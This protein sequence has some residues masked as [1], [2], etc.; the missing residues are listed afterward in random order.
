MTW[1]VEFTDEFGAWWDDL[2]EDDQ[3]KITAAVEVLE[4]HGPNLKRP[5][6]GKIESSRHAQMKELI[7]PAS[8]IRILF[9]FDPRVAGDPAGGRRQG[10]RLA[11]LVRRE[12]SAGGRPLR[13][14]PTRAA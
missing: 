5:V 9:A 1:E 14:L 4:T 3:E 13:H 8:D 11:R 7:P 6:V 10:R 2:A 12:R